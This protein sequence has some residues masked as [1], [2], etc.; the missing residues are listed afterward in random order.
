MMEKW[1]GP[2][3]NWAF[4]L[5]QRTLCANKKE[6]RVYKLVKECT[7]AC[8]GSLRPSQ[9]ISLRFISESLEGVMRSDCIASYSDNLLRIKA[10]RLWTNEWIS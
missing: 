2:R 3:E 10:R 8:K 9:E 7:F 6:T 4:L 5:H 1:N